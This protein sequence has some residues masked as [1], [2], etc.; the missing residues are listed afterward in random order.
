MSKSHREREKHAARRRDRRA[1]RR[2]FAAGER[3]RPLLTWDAEAREWR[4][5]PEPL[6]AVVDITIRAVDHFSAAA[7]QAMAHAR[8]FSRDDVMALYGVRPGDMVVPSRDVFLLPL[9]GVGIDLQLGDDTVKL[10]LVDHAAAEASMDGDIPDPFTAPPDPDPHAWRTV[11]A[12]PFDPDA[13]DAVRAADL[14]RTHEIPH[15]MTRRERAF[16]EL[17]WRFDRWGLVSLPE[18]VRYTTLQEWEITYFMQDLES[19]GF[20][21]SMPQTDD[22]AWLRVVPA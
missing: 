16:E 17:R 19:E 15:T 9:P 13:E 11:V 10:Q 1:E 20:V 7:R 22:P 18:L 12:D 3:Y 21:I 5:N 14:A 6:R 8:Q 2:R 4:Y